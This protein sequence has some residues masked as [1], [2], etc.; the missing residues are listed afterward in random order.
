M[1]VEIFSAYMYLLAI[2]EKQVQKIYRQ[3]HTHTHT[4]TNTQHDYRMP[5]ARLRPPRHK[6]YHTCTSTYNIQVYL[7]TSGALK[8]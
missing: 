6:N 3:I 4:H 1:Y 8:C 2:A 7:I 5:P